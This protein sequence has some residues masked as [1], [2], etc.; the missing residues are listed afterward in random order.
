MYPSTP[1]ERYAAER[2]VDVIVNHCMFLNPDD[3]EYKKL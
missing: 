1:Y 3:K 2:I